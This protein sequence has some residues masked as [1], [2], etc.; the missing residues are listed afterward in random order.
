MKT[1]HNLC[2]STLIAVSFFASAQENSYNVPSIITGDNR[3]LSSGNFSD[4]PT[5]S[6]MIKAGA[7]GLNGFTNAGSGSIYYLLLGDIVGLFDTESKQYIGGQVLTRWTNQHIFTEIKERYEENYWAYPP[8]K[9]STGHT[10]ALGCYQNNPLR[11][12][13]INQ[14]Q[15]NELILFLGS[16]FVAFSPQLKKVIFAETLRVNDWLTTEQT[17]ADM[18]NRN[19]DKSSPF[20][21]LSGILSDTTKVEAGYRGYSKLYFGDFDNNGAAD[22]LVWRKLYKSRASDDE[23]KG[24]VKLRDEW[25]HF[26]REVG[27]DATGEYVAKLT[28]GEQIKTWLTEKNL[29]WQKGYPSKSE[30]PGQTDQLIPEMHD[31]LLNDPDVLQ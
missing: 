23:I 6:I 2:F 17:E 10:V 22:I 5:A 18:E 26:S 27:A 28:T 7:Y 4:M 9:Y 19:P 24:F 15:Q 11:Y 13:D 12:G 16:D 14:D 8:E 1:I 25:Q 20:Q 30:C 29:T 21:H 3:N 31:P